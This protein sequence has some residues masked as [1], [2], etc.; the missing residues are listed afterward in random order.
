MK[1]RAKV[2]LDIETEFY[3]DD[4]SVETLLYCVREDLTDLG[5]DIHDSS[6]SDCD[7]PGGSL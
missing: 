7:L 5:Y 1:I 3:D 6:V 4:D 2:Y